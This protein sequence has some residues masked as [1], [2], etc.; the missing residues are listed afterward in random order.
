MTT[1]EQQ[2]RAKLDTLLQAAG[3]V[4]QDR[5]D[6]NRK[7]AGVI[8]A[9]KSGVTLS[10]VAEQSEKYMVALP[11]HLAR[12][13]THLLFDYESTSDE[14]FFRAMRDPR[15]RSRRVFAFHKPA[16]LHEW[17]KQ[18]NTLRDRLRELPPL[19][20]RGLRD[21]QIDAIGGLEASLAHDRPRSLITA[22]RWK[23]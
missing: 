9:K 13:D 5:K 1:P 2:A 3:W 23:I 19:D 6:F 22:I 14:T 20:K 12:W 4:V 8:E 11:E 7:A 18:G 17:L 10:G 15:P 21:C 16:T